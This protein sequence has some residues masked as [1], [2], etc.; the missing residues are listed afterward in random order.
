MVF[1]IGG[2]LLDWQP[3][4]AYRDLIPDPDELDWFLA[5][6]CTTEWNLSLDAGRPFEEACAELTA[7]HP[8]QAERIAAW[9]HQDVMIAG[10][11]PGTAELV[12]RLNDRGVPLQLLTNMPA[13]VFRARHAAYDVLQLFDGAVVSGEEGVLK[14]DPE[15]FGILVDRFDL[16]P[17][18]TLFVDDSQLNVEGARASGLQA[19]RF[20]DAQRLEATLTE[21]GLL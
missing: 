3:R 4:L 6:V 8:D 14:P 13:D 9:R 7:R 19:H 1:D 11:V 12:R 20:V 17:A 21:L 15:L 5:E 10:E 16:D 18:A 2:V